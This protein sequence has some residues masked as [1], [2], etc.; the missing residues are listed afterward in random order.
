[1]LFTGIGKGREVRI[2][3]VRTSGIFRVK[4]DNRRMSFLFF[5]MGSYKI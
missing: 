3:S 5:G 1:V 4:M 2:E